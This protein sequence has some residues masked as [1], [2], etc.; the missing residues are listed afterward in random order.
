MF[1]YKIVDKDELFLF[2]L[3]L[4]VGISQFLGLDKY[5]NSLKV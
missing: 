2:W 5:S 1:N 3:Q 4:S